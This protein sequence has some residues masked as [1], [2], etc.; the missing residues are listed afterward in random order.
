MSTDAAAELVGRFWPTLYTRDWSALRRFFDADSIYWDVPVGPTAAARG[1]D[2][3][4]RRLRLG[5][6]P[7]EGIDHRGAVVV[8]DGTIVMTE[9]TEVWRFPTG[10]EVALPFVSV[11]HV[12]GEHI[13]L[14]KD[15]WNYGTLMEG[16]PAW[17][18]ERLATADLSWIHD[19]SYLA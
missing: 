19:A 1:P 5:L 10:E 18:H 14:W 11:Q 13:V 7:L 12:R 17:W 6:D 4:E 8:S 3:I 9:H 15:Y 16:A 2:D